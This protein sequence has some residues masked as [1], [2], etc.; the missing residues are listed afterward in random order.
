MEIFVSKEVSYEISPAKSSYQST[1]FPNTPSPYQ[2]NF[3]LKQSRTEVACEITYGEDRYNRHNLTGLVSI[4]I[5]ID[6][7]KVTMNN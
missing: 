2:N 4:Y 3:D 5:P 7:Y 1:N 6:G